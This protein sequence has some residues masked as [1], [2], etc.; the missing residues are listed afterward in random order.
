MLDF[1]NIRFV[2]LLDILLMAATFFYAFHIL[3]G[4]RSLYIFLTIAMLY[5]AR[6]VFAALSMKLMSGLFGAVMDLGLIAV[7]VIFQP[8]IRRFLANLSRKMEQSEINSKVIARLLGRE[9]KEESSVTINALCEACEQMGRDKCGALIVL[10]KQSNIDD[11]VQTGDM[12]DAVVSSR[13]LRNL[14][15]K[16]SPLHDGAVV[17]NGDRVVAARC[18]LPITEQAT[19]AQFGMRHKAAIGVS[20]TT[21]AVVIVVSEETGNVGI[22]KGGVYTSANNP[23]EFKRLLQNG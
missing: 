11:I 4:S 20:E 13:L 10:A 5:L 14:F 12:I 3:R 9:E 21:D 18:T 6:V 15:F 22:V 16:N 7:I 19:P 1:L 8:E 17:I 2:D 23:N